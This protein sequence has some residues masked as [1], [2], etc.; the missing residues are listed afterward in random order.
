[1]PSDPR[2]G[3][4]GPSAGGALDDEGW[5]PQQGPEYAEW[6]YADALLDDGRGLGAA[7]HIRGDLDGGSAETMV[8]GTLLDPAGESLTFSHDMPIE[9]LE[10]NKERLDV[11]LGPCSLVH[12]GDRYH[13]VVAT[14]EVEADLVMQPLGG[15]WRPP[16]WQVYTTP[17]QSHF[18]AWNVPVVSAALSGTVTAGGRTAQVTGR[19]YIDHSWMTENVFRHCSGWHWG[20]FYSGEHA[21]VYQLMPRQRTGVDFMNAFGYFYQ[22]RVQFERLPDQTQVFAGGVGKIK[23]PLTQHLYASTNNFDLPENDVLRDLVVSTEHV[24][25]RKIPLPDQLRGLQRL[26]VSRVV[27]PAT[28]KS[29][30]SFSATVGAANRVHIEGRGITELVFSR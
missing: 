14:E 25:P 7:F 17:D 28:I 27:K 22:G 16:E 11:R 13:L 4:L 24:V 10:A 3:N 1:M 15:G 26:I 2:V 18:L 30:C 20:R 23:D 6:W 8:R 29:L 19:G 9:Q 5:Q 21:I 12:E